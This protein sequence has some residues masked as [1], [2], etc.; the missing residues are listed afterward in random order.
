[1]FGFP[2][3]KENPEDL[4]NDI[5]EAVYSCDPYGYMDE[6][7][8]GEPIEV[9]RG[10]NRK[11]ITSQIRKKDKSLLSGLRDMRDSLEDENPTIAERFS[12]LIKRL[13]AIYRR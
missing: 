3:K 10:N 9:T 6:S 11:I 1:M 7:P 5:D 4:A 2:R 8:T 13:E 12:N